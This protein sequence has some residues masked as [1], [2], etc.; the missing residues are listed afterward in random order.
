VRACVCVRACVRAC[1][2]VCVRACVCMRLYVSVHVCGC[3]WGL[4]VR[5]LMDVLAQRAHALASTALHHGL[6]QR[7]MQH[8]SMQLQR[9]WPRWCGGVCVCFSDEG[10]QGEP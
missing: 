7:C 1:V 5:A 6:R 10:A 8:M 3:V 9:G 4:G 2:H